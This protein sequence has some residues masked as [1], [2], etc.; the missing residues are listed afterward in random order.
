MN[1]FQM[2][3]LVEHHVNKAVTAISLHQGS[4]QFTSILLQASKDLEL[5]K[6]RAQQQQIH[7]QHQRHQIHGHQFHQ[8]R[9]RQSLK[10]RINNH[11]E[12]EMMVMDGIEKIRNALKN[13]LNDFNFIDQQSKKSI[14]QLINDL[15][16][17]IS[18]YDSKLDQVKAYYTKLTA[19]THQN[20][21]IHRPL[22]TPHQP[23]A[24]DPVMILVLVLRVLS[25]VPF[26][27]K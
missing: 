8:Q 7:L 2:R 12:I 26:K 19:T 22:P 11:S 4:D 6:K 9:T 15:A 5:L 27:R 17:E 24:L 20:P 14:N 10:D 3:K 16:S 18:S 21:S 13:H 25:L 23:N 1:T